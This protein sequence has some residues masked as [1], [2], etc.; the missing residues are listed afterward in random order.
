MFRHQVIR[1]VI[2]SNSLQFRLFVEENI[3]E[4]GSALNSARKAIAV[5]TATVAWI[6][7]YLPVIE[8][9]LFDNYS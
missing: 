8:K 1:F 7:K 4:L 2:I 3:E 5:A 9:A 6:N